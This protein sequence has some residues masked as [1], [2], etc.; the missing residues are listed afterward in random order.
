[1]SLPNLTVPAGY[2]VTIELTYFPQT[3]SPLTANPNLVTGAIF[4][5]TD[6]QVT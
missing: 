3:A 4:T 2:R 1:M 6:G 5:V